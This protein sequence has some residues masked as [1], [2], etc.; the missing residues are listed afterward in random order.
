MSAATAN[1]PVAAAGYS[2][3]PLVKK[4]GL[5]EGMR[6]VFVREPDDFRQSLGDLP[7]GVKVTSQ[8]RGTKDYIHVFAIK[9]SDL[10]R[11]LE[12]VV[13]VL[14]VDGMAWISWPKRASGVATDVDGAVVRRLGLAAGL[15]DIK[16]CAVDSVWSG[17][18]FV[19][20]KEDRAAI[21]AERSK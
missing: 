6:A 1:N 9:A 11:K 15:V 7:D 16:V 8:L 13:R 21:R 14:E 20:R 2:L 10:E 17:H 18:K 19:F 12:A 3:R 4:L 5:K